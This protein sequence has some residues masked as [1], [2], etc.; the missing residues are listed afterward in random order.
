MQSTSKKFQGLERSTGD[1]SSAPLPRRKANTAKPTA[2]NTPSAQV[3]PTQ[4]KLAQ[5]KSTVGISE[6]FLQAREAAETSSCSSASS[7]R[8]ADSALSSSSSI[9]AARNKFKKDEETTRVA[10]SSATTPKKGSS[11]PSA[12]AKSSVQAARSKFQEPL[13]PVP[14]SSSSGPANIAKRRSSDSNANVQA[15]RNKFK[16]EESSSSNQAATAAKQRLS[17]SPASNANVQAARERFKAAQNSSEH[18]SATQ[19]S[20]RKS[21]NQER[22][23]KRASN[24]EVPG[25]ARGAR[26][27]VHQDGKPSS[28][29]DIPAGVAPSIGQAAIPPAVNKLRSSPAKTPTNREGIRKSANAEKRNSSSGASSYGDTVKDIRATSDEELMAEEKKPAMKELKSPEGSDDKDFVEAKERLSGSLQAARGLLNQKAPSL[30]SSSGD[31]PKKRSNHKAWTAHANVM[32]PPPPRRQTKGS[33][34]ARSR[35]VSTPMVS[36]TR[37]S[38]RLRPN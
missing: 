30:S 33:N 36:L 35:R 1:A 26:S 8:T 11:D 10:S 5:G 15:A 23:E 7:A 28:M 17:A 31:S 9:Q 32:T 18:A 16:Q 29:S 6:R 22:I 12:G 37:R 24:E 27:Q 20:L 13:E 14:S 25:V 21:F 4:G 3:A 19:P 38:S 34:E 2:F